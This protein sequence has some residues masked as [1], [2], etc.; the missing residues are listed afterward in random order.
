M[1]R[2]KH[3]IKPY[4]AFFIPAGCPH[5]YYSTDESWDTHWIKPSGKSCP[6]MLKALGFDKP[7]IFPLQ[8]K[9]LHILTTVSDVCTRH[10]CLTRLTEISE[11]RA[12][13]TAFSLN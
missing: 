12:I 1:N 9:K 3:I 5:E 6:D 8:R 7:K 2:E 13:C 4:T 10:S 11:R